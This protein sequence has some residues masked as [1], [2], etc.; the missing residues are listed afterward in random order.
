MS[1]GAIFW[2][3][4]TST[5]LNLK[6]KP[7]QQPDSLKSIQPSPKPCNGHDVAAGL[8]GGPNHG[9]PHTRPRPVYNTN[10]TETYHKS[11]HWSFDVRYVIRQR[12]VRA[13]AGGY[14]R[15]PDKLVG[16]GGLRPSQGVDGTSAGICHAPQTDRQ[17]ENQSDT[18]ENKQLLL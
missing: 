7:W 1:F 18:G 5:S 9:P 14:C 16:R 3:R 10:L 15:G 4:H 2:T 17:Y 11:V 6:T 13:L 12:L 8:V